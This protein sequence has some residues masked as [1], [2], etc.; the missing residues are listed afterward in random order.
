MTLEIQG[1]AQKCGG[2][3]PINE[4][5]THPSIVDTNDKK[6]GTDSLPKNISPVCHYSNPVDGRTKIDH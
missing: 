2:I 1:Q 3:K 4:I 6:T 5:P